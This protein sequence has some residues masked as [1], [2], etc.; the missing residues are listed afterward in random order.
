MGMGRFETCPYM[1]SQRTGKKNHW[2]SQRFYRYGSHILSIDVNN[3]GS[4]GFCGPSGRVWSFA[5]GEK[6]DSP[7]WK[8]WEIK[9]LVDPH[10][11]GVRYLQTGKAKQYVVIMIKYTDPSGFFHFICSVCLGLKNISPL[12]GEKMGIL[13]FPGFSPWAIIFCLFK[14]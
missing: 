7:G 14:A 11:E 4:L 2:F 10:P 1:N 13:L 5:E 12:Q 6:C 8:P 3:P 9:S